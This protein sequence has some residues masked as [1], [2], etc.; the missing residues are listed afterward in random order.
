MKHVRRARVGFLLVSVAVVGS[1]SAVAG[2]APTAATC[3]SGTNSS[4]RNS[5]TRPTTS[6]THWI[7]S[8]LSATSLGRHTTPYAL[9]Y[10]NV[11]AGNA[12]KP[13][14]TE[15]SAGG[16]G[17]RAVVVVEFQVAPADV[18]HCLGFPVPGH[19]LSGLGT[20]RS[21][22]QS[23]RQALVIREEIDNRYI[24][25]STWRHIAE[26]HHI[27]GENDAKRT[28]LQHA[29]TIL[30]HLGHADAHMILILLTNDN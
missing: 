1:P 13:S 9:G 16:C 19:R 25:A 11:R 22:L 4:A 26:V 8:P 30:E 15:I 18:V 17:Q 7:C 5:T 3:E 14:S 2:P 29:L 23:Y 10:L 27:T 6:T 24:Q 21:S 28:A 20:T 12:L